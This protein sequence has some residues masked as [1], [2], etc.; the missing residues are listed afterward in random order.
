MGSQRQTNATLRKTVLQ[1]SNWQHLCEGQRPDAK[2]SY[3]A[4]RMLLYHHG[5]CGQSRQHSE[6]KSST[7][8]RLRKKAQFPHLSLAPLGVE[9]G[10]HELPPQ[11]GTP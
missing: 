5:V 7:Y 10:S 9:N 4:P 3:V 1:V 2:T 11:C 8:G 6:P